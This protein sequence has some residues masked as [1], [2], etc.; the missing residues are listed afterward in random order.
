MNWYIQWLAFQPTFR[1]L[2]EYFQYVYQEAVAEIYI[3][4]GFQSWS[5][6]FV[7]SHA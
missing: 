5:K 3:R 6:F 2:T 1:R 7:T 4:Q